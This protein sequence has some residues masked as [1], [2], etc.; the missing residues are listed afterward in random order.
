MVTHYYFDTSS[1]L[2]LNVYGLIKRLRKVNAIIVPE[3]LKEIL[4]RNLKRRLEKISHYTAQKRPAFIPGLDALD[5]GERGIIRT[6]LCAYNRR[7]SI[8]V[9]NDTDTLSFI[10]TYPERIC[11]RV[12]DTSEFV[13][14]LYK[15]GVV[16]KADIQRILSNNKRRPNRKCRKNLERALLQN[17]D[18]AS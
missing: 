17:T 18:D 11:K 7:L 13:I 12:M 15:D 3:V 4:D 1:I 2:D 10:D 8:Y 16:R 6:M 14:K 9:S 5:Y